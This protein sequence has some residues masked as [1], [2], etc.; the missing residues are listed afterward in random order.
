MAER[1]GFEPSKHFHAYTVSNR[2]PSATRTPLRGARLGRSAL[3][4]ATGLKNGGERGIRTLDTVTRIAV[5]ET[6]RFSHSRISPR[7]RIR[8]S[9]PV[10][11]AVVGHRTALFEE[12]REQRSA[13]FREH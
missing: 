7:G 3:P 1:E 2:A 5:F 9:Q 4:C 8:E 12:L 11:H 10:F 13:F 6:A